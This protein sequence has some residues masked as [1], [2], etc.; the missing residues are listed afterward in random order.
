M[1]RNFVFGCFIFLKLF[2]FY[3]KSA[4]TKNHRTGLSDI[5]YLSPFSRDSNDFQKFPKIFHSV[6]KSRFEIFSNFNF[7]FLVIIFQKQ[8]SN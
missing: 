2:V 7:R 6:E 5:S 1:G 3:A 4:T 8:F